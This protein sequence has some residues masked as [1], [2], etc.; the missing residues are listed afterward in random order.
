MSSQRSRRVAAVATEASESLRDMAGTARYRDGR[1]DINWISRR[2][3]PRHRMLSLDGQWYD[4][5]RLRDML[6]RRALERARRPQTRSQT[7]AGGE[8]NTVPASRR[9][10][11]AAESAAVRDPNP[12]RLFED[13][14]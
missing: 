2:Q 5:G 8:Q 7:R 9:P 4:R 11:T 12:W 3:M 10:M 1:L 13:D 14:A 6:D